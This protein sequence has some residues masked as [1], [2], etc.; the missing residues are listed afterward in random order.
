MEAEK[1]KALSMYYETYA[2]LV[3]GR[4][5]YIRWQAFLRCSH[6]PL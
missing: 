3:V 5:G 4:D 6:W 2:T 1:R